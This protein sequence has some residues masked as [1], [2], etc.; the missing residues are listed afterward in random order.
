MKI[1]YLHGIGSGAESRTPRT[2]REHLNKDEIFAPEIPIDPLEAYDFVKKTAKDFSPDVVVGTSLGAFYAMCLRGVYKLLINPAMYAA[3]DIAKGLGIGK[4]PFYLPRSDNATEYEIDKAFI[5][6][7]AALENK[8]G[9][10]IDAE[11]K[12]HTYALFG[13]RDALLNHHT[14]FMIEYDASHAQRFDGEHR[15]SPEDIENVVL[16]QVKRLR[17]LAYEEKRYPRLFESAFGIPVGDPGAYK[18][19]CKEL[20]AGFDAL[21]ADKY[22]TFFTDPAA[23]YTNEDFER[24]EEP[25]CYCDLL[26]EYLLLLRGFTDARYKVDY[27]GVYER[28]ADLYYPDKGFVRVEKFTN[29][30]VLKYLSAPQLTSLLIVY[31]STFNR[32]KPGLFLGCCELGYT[33]EILKYLKKLASRD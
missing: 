24:T 16:P 25:N 30:G 9:E 10:G 20:F 22:M 5:S 33:G 7:L 28:I 31:S 26:A 27:P 21:V 4:K 19:R 15:L 6:K 23:N 1:L 12:K 13:R 11:E 3:E 18:A 17:A 2:L 32:L 14:D 29:D 8:A